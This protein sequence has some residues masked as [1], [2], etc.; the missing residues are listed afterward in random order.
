MG[1]YIAWIISV[2]LSIQN[3]YVNSLRLTNIRPWECPNAYMV[4]IYRLPGVTSLSFCSHPNNMEL[5][6][7]CFYVTSILKSVNLSVYWIKL[8]NHRHDQLYFVVGYF[9]IIYST[10]PFSVEKRYCTY[11]MH[12]LYN[13]LQLH[14]LLFALSSC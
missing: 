4:Y 2:H 9:I 1:D 3:K 6:Q 13:I 5:S 12:F 7:P 11:P 10:L 14:R 8:W